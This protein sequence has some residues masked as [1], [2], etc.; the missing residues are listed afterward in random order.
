MNEENEL[1][2]TSKPTGKG[3]ADAT[4]YA[5]NVS[6]D[7]EKCPFNEQEPFEIW[8]EREVEGCGI[9][10]YSTDD[11]KEAWKSIKSLCRRAWENGGYVGKY[12]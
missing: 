1:Q 7:D 12:I 4:C 8:W 9:E 2:N 6:K 3:L 5:E 10:M 11:K